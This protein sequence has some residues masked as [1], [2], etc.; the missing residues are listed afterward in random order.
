MFNSQN[1]TTF[2]KDNFSEKW[3]SE[4]GRKNPKKHEKM[5]SD[6]DIGHP[7]SNCMFMVSFTVLF[8]DVRGC[9]G[10]YTDGCAE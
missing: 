3:L 10:V 7:D 9:R 2:S 1:T 4:I 8:K 6:N 5:L